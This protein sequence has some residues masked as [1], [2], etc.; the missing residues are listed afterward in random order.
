MPTYKIILVHF[1]LFTIGCIN[2]LSQE[3]SIYQNYYLSPFIINP[4]VTGS[5]DYTVAEMSYKKQWLGIKDSPNTFLLTGN[6]RLGTYDFYDPKKFLNKGPLKIKDRIGLGAAI[7][8][9]ND[10]PLSYTEAIISYAYHIPVSDVSNLSLGISAIGSV[11]SINTSML[12]PDQDNDSYL[13]SGNDKKFRANFNFGTY[14]YNNTY[15]AGFS[16]DKILPDVANAATPKKELPSYFLFGGYKFMKTNNSFNVEPSVTVKK[17]GSEKLS[18]DIHSKFYIKRLNWLALSYSTTGKM[19]IQFGL[20][21]YQMIYAGYNYE[22]SFSKISAYNFGSH[23]I[24]L[25]IN[26]GLTKVEGIRETGK[27]AK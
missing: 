16:I 8:S 26:L 5:E 19:D 25:G 17:L 4:A 13:L 18:V 11:N 3:S 9:D 1:L 2:A 10:G 14:Y 27:N 12:K 20:H 15:F 6:Y 23:E 21:L 22:Y 7:F 24:Y